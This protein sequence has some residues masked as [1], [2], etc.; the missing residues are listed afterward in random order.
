MRNKLATFFAA[1]A[2]IA[3]AAWGQ[4]LTDV[5]RTAAPI[6]GAGSGTVT[7]VSVTTAN[8]V[9]GSVANASTLP[10]ISLSL[11]AITPSS[12]STGT[13]TATYISGTLTSATGLPITTG[14]SGM[15]AS[16]ST[17]LATPTVA[18]LAA[19]CPQC[20]S[21][22]PVNSQSASYTTT[23]ADAGKAIY[24]PAA[25]TTTRTW[26]IDSNATVPYPIGT[27][28][29]FDN[30]YGAGAITIAIASDT[31]VLVGAAGSTGSRTLASGGQATA[32]KVTSTRWRING[33]GLT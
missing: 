17:F 31:L 10:A 11:G 30:D 25:D 5:T 18:N 9:S 24:H 16:V 22:V 3:A 28:I 15:A 26:T 2:L 13:V 4:V 23:L 7:G 29:T 12:V 19:A 6:L 32:I 20:T 1:A 21:V 27:V 14:V 33:T 8:G